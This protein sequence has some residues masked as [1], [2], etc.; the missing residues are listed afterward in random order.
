[1]VSRVFEFFELIAEELCDDSDFVLTSRDLEGRDK[2]GGAF[3]TELM[4]ECAV[5]SQDEVVPAAVAKIE[6]HFAT[7]KLTLPFTFDRKKSRFVLVERSVAEFIG[8]CSATRSLTK[9]SREFEEI[10]LN[11]LGERLPGKLHRVG[12]P[13]NKGTKIAKVNEHL[14]T[15]FG[16]KDDVLTGADKDGGFDILWLV[17]LGTEAFQPLFSIQCKNGQFR[18]ED[19]SSSV[20][21]SNRSLANHRNLMPEAHVNCVVFNDYLDTPVRFRRGVQYVPIGL[22]DLFGATPARD[23]QSL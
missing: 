3:V 4:Q 16:F 22:S 8:R 21:Q 19:A 10:V 23:I 1:M 15:E 17:P 14:R 12:A 20:A 7:K 5:A 6:R 9:R 18:D 2:G 11:R 13:R